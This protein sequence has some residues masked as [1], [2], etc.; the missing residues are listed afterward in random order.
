[1]MKMNRYRAFSVAVLTGWLLMTGCSETELQ[2]VILDEDIADPALMVA[3]ARGSNSEV[4][5]IWA[6]GV[7]YHYDV[8]S[9]TDDF[10]NDGTANGEIE[11]TTSDFSDRQIDDAWNQGMEGAWAGLNA[12]RIMGEAFDDQTFQTSPLVARMFINSG[13]SERLIGDAYC[14]AVYNFGPDGGFLLPGP[15]VY[16]PSVIVPRDSIF[17]RMATV[18]QLGLEQAERA[19]AAG[20]PTPDGDSGFDP[21]RL[22]TLA[23]GGLAQAH[24][25]MASLGR[26]P[27]NNWSLAVQ[28]AKEVPTDFVFVDIHDALVEI[29]ELWD[30][31]WDNDDVTMWGAFEN[32][33]LVG[34]PATAMWEDDPRV[35]VTH[36]GDFA[37]PSAGI[38]SSIV[39]N[40]ACSP[41][42]DHRA[43]SNQVPDWAPDKYA[44]RGDDVPMVKGTE[45]RLI[46]AEAALVAGN[47]GEF[48]NQVNQVR[49]F[50]G[51]DDIAMPSSVGTFEWPNAEDDAWSILDRER[52]LT[53]WLEGR[54]AFDL[55]RWNHPFL[56]EG[57]SLI[58]RHDERITGSRAFSCIPIPLG[59]CNLNT[60][61]TCENLR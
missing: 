47:L 4:T 32:G 2:G 25:A 57:V 11:L 9:S 5:D 42:S 14:E 29:N 16:D 13:L 26:D 59:E 38:G 48:T 52:Y 17:Q 21:M 34:T 37:D 40:N 3:L 6:V 18:M 43:E 20:V 10:L 12:I 39:D 56:T 36:C 8:L 44:D 31:T 28:H 30:I 24:M 27:A 49:S 46:E 50:Y 35:S 45:M 55:S 58:P 15:G 53:L 23:H 51:L 22:R 33:R 61:L 7:G 1:M 19:I 41:N 60:Q 54:R